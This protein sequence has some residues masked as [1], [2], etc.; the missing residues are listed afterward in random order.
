MSKSVQPIKTSMSVQRKL[1]VAVGLLSFA[2]FVIQGLSKSWGF[3]AVG[4]QLVQTALVFSAG[5]NI[6]FLGSSVQKEITEKEDEE[7]E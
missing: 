7:A 2:A 5:I 6:Y 1:S 3:E 4:E